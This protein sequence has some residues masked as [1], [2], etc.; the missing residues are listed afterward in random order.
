M[1]SSQFQFA[2]QAFLGDYKRHYLQTEIKIE[3]YPERTA[4]IWQCHNQFPMK[5]WRGMTP[6][7]PCWW[8]V[9]EGSGCSSKGVYPRF[10]V[11]G[12][13]KGFFWVWNF[14][15]LV[16]NLASI[17]FLGWLDFSRDFFFIFKTI[18]ILVVVPAYPG[19]I[20]L[21]TKYNQT[22]FYNLV[23]HVK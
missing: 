18:R 16:G 23:F 22:Y 10:Q 13:I 12:I 21:Q 7:I 9:T 15:F 6:E 14:L 20:V 11:T 17:N 8:S 3:H 5:W 19:Y 2:R 1:L 4:Y